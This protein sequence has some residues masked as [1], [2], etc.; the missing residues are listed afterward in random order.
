MPPA[1][2]FHIGPIPI[3]G[4]VILSPMDGLSDWPFRSLCRQLGSA[5]SYTEF[6]KA[7]EVLDPPKQIADK[8]YYEEDERP[9]VIQL[10]GDEPEVMRSAALRAQELGADIVDVNMGCPSRTIASRGAGVGLMRTPSKVARIFEL[11]TAS[12]AIPVSGK[13]RLGWD[14]DSQTYPL[15]ARVVEENGGSL[16]ALHGR[17]KMQGYGG[18]A[19]WDA[20][21]EV[22]SIVNIP[23]IGNGDVK[24]VADIQRMKDYT[25][26]DAVMI[27]RAAIGNPWIFSRL[28]REQV[29][30]EQ[31]RE[32]MLKHLE[33]NFEFYGPEMGLV[34]FRKHAARYLS[35][36]PLSKEI[37]KKLLTSQRQEEF[38]SMLDDIFERVNLSPKEE[39]YLPGP[40]FRK[41]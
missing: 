38:L 12:L 14:D 36:Y 1:P 5:M 17:T 28:D 19:N 18:Q 40:R 13:I 20:I 3:H 26:C 4:D 23:V 39:E 34:L 10:Y 29:S 15:I 24:T 25:Q 33:H 31:V 6:V 21:A 11:L 27:G 30:F 41:G 9:V 7:E 35:P 22:K 16:I 32:M 37:R 8:L 2:T